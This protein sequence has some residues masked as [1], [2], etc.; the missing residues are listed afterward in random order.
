MFI[1]RNSRI[2]KTI[3]PDMKRFVAMLQCILLSAVVLVSQDRDME[4]AVLFLSGAASMEE[5]DEEVME[6][7]R[8]S[9]ARPLRINVVPESRLV[10]SGLFSRYQA[11]SLTDY[12]KMN[13]DILSASELALV[14]GFNADL[15]EALRFFVSFDSYATPGR[16]GSG[17][18]PVAT[19]TLSRASLRSQGGGETWNYAF[20]MRTG[21][22]D[23]WSA[24]L[25]AKSGYEG[26]KWPPEAFSGSAAIY[27]R[28][29]RWTLVA[30]DFNARFGQGLLCWTGF[31][32]TGAQSASSF[33]RHP[34]G[35]TQA[36]TVSPSAARRGIAGEILIGRVSLSSFWAP[37]S[38]SGASLTWSAKYGQL[39]L[40]AVTPARTSADWRWSLGRY[41]IFGE[42]AYDAAGRASAGVAGC[43]FNPGYESRISFLVRSYAP[44]YDGTGAGAFRSSTKTSDERGAAFAMDFR[45]LAVTADAAFHPS[46]GTS[47]HKAV[48][49]YGADISEVIGLNCRLSS[50]FRP[51]DDHRWRNEARIE[52]E[53]SPSAC[54]PFR[55]CA[56]VCS[57]DGWAWLSFVEAG[58]RHEDSASSFYAYGRFTVF[59]VDDWDDRIYVYERDVPGT[60]S[61]PAYYGRGISWSTVISFKKKGKWTLNAKISSLQYPLMEE[62]KDGKTEARIQL[63][64]D[65]QFHPGLDVR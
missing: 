53:Y 59:E 40:T 17:R 41:D 49:K 51:E 34:S 10:A 14:D 8:S 58:Y 3:F 65:F 39:G 60:F 24:A 21:A 15:A 48:L 37:Q 54:F 52:A 46:K 22:E 47:Q 1:C 25:A 45:N 2:L 19:E 28:G 56:D 29:G 4:K 30:G 57:C 5:L 32:L 11:A 12:R 33:A 63:V 31:S 61:A 26:S 44:S 64:R 9:S 27:G 50:R 62:G 13:G 43:T 20:K 38:S 6:R 36:W 7:F 35:I 16:K 23:R 55:I 42:M 18:S